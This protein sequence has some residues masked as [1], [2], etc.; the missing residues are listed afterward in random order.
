M[1]MPNWNIEQPAPRALWNI[2]HSHYP[3][4]KFLGILT[5]PGHEDH[6]E[7]RALDVGL[8]AWLSA[9]KQLADMLV[10]VLVDFTAEVRWSYIIWNK[11]IWYGDARSGP[12]PY[13][14]AAKMPHTEH[15][16]ISW[17]QASSQG[18]TFLGFSLALDEELRRQ[19]GGVEDDQTQ[20]SSMKPYSTP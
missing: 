12:H 18:S 16:H 8:R 14:R 6:S 3:Q 13:G 5:G 19:W 20:S 11:Q 9:E 1:A 4:T 15:I 7:G 17:S 10:G 2:I